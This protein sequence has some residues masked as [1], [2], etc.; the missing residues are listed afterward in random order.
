MTPIQIKKIEYKSK[1][2]EVEHV[3]EIIIDGVNEPIPTSLGRLSHHPIGKTPAGWEVLDAT[4]HTE[5]FPISGLG[6]LPDGEEWCIK[7]K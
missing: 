6:R 4:K 2:G 3:E 1:K 5:I 7:I